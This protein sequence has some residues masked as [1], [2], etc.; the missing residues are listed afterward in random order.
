MSKGKEELMRTVPEDEFRQR[1]EKAREGVNRRGLDAL[2]VHS[3]EVEFA[4]VRYLS[5]YWPAFESAGVLIPKEGEAILIIGPESETYARD[6]SKISKIRKILEYRESAEPEYPGVIMS[7]FEEIF[8]ESV[9]EGVKKLGIAGYSIMPLSIYEAIRRAIPDAEIIR[10]DDILVQ[11][12]IKKSPN[13][14]MLL[15]E[16]S[17]ISEIALGEVL[18][19]IHPGVTE[20]QMVG[21]AQKAMYENGAE[22]E[23]HPQYVFSGKGTTHAV[24][25]PSYRVLKEGEMIQLGIGARVGGYSASIG[26]PLC[27]GKMPSEMRKLV[28]A[29]LDAHLRTM[30]WMKAG[31]P[32]REVAKKFYDYLTDKGFGKNI[33]YGPCHGLGMMEVEKPW[34]ELDSQYVLEENMTFQV[35]TFLYTKD[36]GLRW[37][38]GVR[39]TKEGVERFSTKYLEILEL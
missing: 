31:V 36:Y 16:A 13:E 34:I 6:R 10:A 18:K 19:A 8:R 38:D 33:L 21:V 23:A 32:A 2:L 14:I 20:L 3:N 28:Q 22:Y 9:S 4:N 15:K 26:R 11:M 5:D 12:R 39:V 35:D 1:L 37:E 30:D 7:T 17:R 24:S 27:L 25:R 29:G